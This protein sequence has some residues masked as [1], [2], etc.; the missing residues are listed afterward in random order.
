MCRNDSEGEAKSNN[1]LIKK[2]GKM[3]EKSGRE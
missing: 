1:S 3:E 2:K